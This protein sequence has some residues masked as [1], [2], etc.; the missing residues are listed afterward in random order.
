MDCGFSCEA[1]IQIIILCLSQI[2]AYR[3]YANKDIKEMQMHHHASLPEAMQPA[4][5]QHSNRGWTAHSPWCTS[6]A[7]GI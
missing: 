3:S 4:L 7:Q 5:F 1:L 6:A 2:S